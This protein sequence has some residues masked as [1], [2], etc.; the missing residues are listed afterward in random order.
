MRNIENIKKIFGFAVF[1]V[2]LFAVF[3]NST[4]TYDTTKRYH[5]V[6]ETIESYGITTPKFSWNDYAVS[7]KQ[8]GNSSKYNDTFGR[9]NDPISAIF[10]LILYMYPAFYVC[11]YGLLKVY[12]FASKDMQE[13]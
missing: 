1:L 6:R 3:Y 5:N 8:K 12:A 9:P 13:N 4:Q 2:C 11:L 10:L 7:T